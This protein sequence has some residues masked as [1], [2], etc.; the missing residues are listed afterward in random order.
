MSDRLVEEP[1]LWQVLDSYFRQNGL[2]KQQIDSYNRFTSQI[3][4][5][6]SQYGKFSI[7]MKHQFRIGEEING[8][9]R[10]E[11]KFDNKLYKSTTNHKN[12][13]KSVIKVNP[14]MC[15]LR[16]LNYQSEVKVDLLYTKINID[17]E[18]NTETTAWTKSIPKIPM[19]EL[20]VM[21]RSNWCRLN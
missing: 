13:D 7:P 14:M 21:A 2:V 3:E 6:I 19:A 15:R 12:S 17:T 8:Q 5:V 16:D 10:W 20:P 18:N 4:Q 9:E 11:F 1:H